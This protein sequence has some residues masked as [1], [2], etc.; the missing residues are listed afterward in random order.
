M[1][2]LYKFGA[3]G[4]SLVQEVPQGETDGVNKTYQTSSSFQSGTLQVYYNGQLFREGDDYEVF[5]DNKFKLTYIAPY[6]GDVLNTIYYK[7]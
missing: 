4:G 7:G 6:T 3:A 5:D 2:V 1:V